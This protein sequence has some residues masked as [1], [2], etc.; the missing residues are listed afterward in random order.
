MSSTFSG[1]KIADEG[2]VYATYGSIKYLK[3]VIASIIS[4]RRY[5]KDRPVALFCSEDHLA[6]IEKNSLREHINHIFILPEEYRSITGFKHN[7]YRFMPFHRNLYLDSDIVWCREPRNLWKAFSAYRFTI[8]GNQVSDLFFG[9]HKGF[10]VL[11]DLLLGSR[12]RTLKRFGL[13]YLS[14]VQS[15]MIYAG[16]PEL[17]EE[18][19]ELAKEMLRRRKETH[20][21]S[22]KEEQGRSEESC[23]WSFAMAMSRLKVQVF[24][25]LNG[26]E[27]PQLDF[28]EN[29]TRYDNSFENVECLLF[30]SQFIYDL[31]GLKNR[32]L[33]KSLIRLLTL[34]PGKG[35]Y[36][37]VTPYCLH[38]GWYHQ[39]EPLNRFSNACWANVT[40]EPSSV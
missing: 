4:L 12:K 39:K 10:G 16:D 14:R 18:V 28:I 34:L 20:F 23:E 40:K 35:D 36:L 24:P 27:S 5:D 17:T 11:K 15:G 38:F 37:Y 3:H 21:R 26:Y 19:C 6:V 33:Q 7:V 32:F 22:R 30:G 1:N 31:K 9:A 29:Y 8:T 2:Y 13:T 25:W